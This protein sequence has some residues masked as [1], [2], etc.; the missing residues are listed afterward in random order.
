M[1]V[2]WTGNREG[3]VAK[4]WKIEKKEKKKKKGEKKKNFFKGERGFCFFA[5]ASGGN[6]LPIPKEKKK[7]KRKN[8]VVLLLLGFSEYILYPT[9]FF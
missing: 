5:R 3:E 2:G 7:K 1:G 4:V 6:F 9:S 8:C